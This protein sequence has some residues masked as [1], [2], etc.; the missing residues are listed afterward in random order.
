MEWV[1][2]KVFFP[3]R[4]ALLGLAT[5]VRTRKTGWRCGPCSSA[6]ISIRGESCLSSGGGLLKLHND[7][8]TCGYEDVQV[9]WEM[10]KKTET[11]QDSPKRRRPLWR[12]SS[13][14]SCRRT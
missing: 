11:S 13:W 8:Q 2:N 14:G 4:K 12:L 9:M 5:R 6:L 3:V 1:L 10:L 7:V